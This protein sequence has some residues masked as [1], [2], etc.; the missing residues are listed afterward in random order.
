M[1]YW[2]TCALYLLGL[3]WCYEVITRV[4]DDVE[5]LREVKDT[6]RRATILIRHCSFV[7][8]LSDDYAF[9]LLLVSYQQL[10]IHQGNWCPVLT[11]FKQY[12]MG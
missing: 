2:M 8:C 9:H 11:P 7:R 3:S 5:E 10:S 1:V 6:T 12:C 4:R